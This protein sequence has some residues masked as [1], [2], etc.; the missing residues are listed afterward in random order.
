[1]IDDLL[2][3]AKEM[4]ETSAQADPSPGAATTKPLKTSI[5]NASSWLTSASSW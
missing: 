1:M 4:N 2:A 3:E 5:A